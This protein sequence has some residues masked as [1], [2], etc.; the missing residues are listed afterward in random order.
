MT[1]ERFLLGWSQTKSQ[2]G[3]QELTGRAFGGWDLWCTGSIP[4]GLSGN[5]SIYGAYAEGYGVYSGYVGHSGGPYHSGADTADSAT[6]NAPA[7]APALPSLVA[8]PAS[9][10][11]GTPRRGPLTL[12][13][14][15]GCCSSCCC[16]GCSLPL[17]LLQL[18]L[19]LLLPLLLLSP[20]TSFP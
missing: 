2:R 17:P 18:R 8:S 13:G 20:A 11:R 15:G 12:D 5:A 4:P 9:W 14:C 7:P 19:L 1:R 3:L 10:R 16:C 6:L